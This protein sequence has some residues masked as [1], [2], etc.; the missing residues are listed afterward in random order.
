M[1][2]NSFEFLLFFP[3]VLFLLFVLPAAFRVAFLLCAGYFFYG[4]WKIEYTFLIGFSTLLDYFCGLAIGKYERYKRFFAAL[5]ICTNLAILFTFKY[6]DF[7]ISEFNNVASIWDLQLP[8]YAL[9]LPVG[10]S[11]YTFQSIA[12]IMETYWGRVKPEKNFIKFAAYIV[13]FPQLVA[14]PI[15]RPQN[16]LPQMDPKRFYFDY[17]RMRSGLVLI[18][19]GFFK[20]VVIADN[21]AL[22]VNPVFNNWES[23]SGLT[24][25][26]AG[27]LFAFQIYCDFSGYT[28]IARGASKMMGVDLMENFRSP[29][30]SKSPTEFWR[31]WHISLS[32][33]FKDYLYIPLGGNRHSLARHMVIIMIVFAVSGLWH[34]AN[35]TFI[36]WGILN[37]LYVIGGHLLRSPFKFENFLSKYVH[38]QKIINLMKILA[39]FILIDISWFFFRSE[40]VGQAVGML[41][42]SFDSLLTFKTSYPA[43]YTEVQTLDVNVTQSLIMILILKLVHFHLGER[44]IDEYVIAQ[45]TAVR[46]TIY[47]ALVLTVLFFGYFGATE[48]IYFQF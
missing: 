40:T 22:F 37:G 13:Y 9:I 16:L 1:L 44:K 19:F 43:L 34:G 10:I 8:L 32:T 3:T 24:C 7:F 42:K 35:W 21:I 33:W 27:I 45:N 36:I 6:H 5:S 46:W 39:T 14:G 2:F 25:L 38:S 48:F 28:D 18:L 15:E 20:K 30:F 31:R 29:Y 41:K 17:D 11:F 12:Y 47:Y 23:Y 26:L 4:N